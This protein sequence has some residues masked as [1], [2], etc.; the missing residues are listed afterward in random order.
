MTFVSTLF[1]FGLSGLVLAY[2]IVNFVTVSS[3][4]SSQANWY[5]YGGCVDEYTA[6]GAEEL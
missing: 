6:V 2:L 1:M 3:M 4:Y 5:E